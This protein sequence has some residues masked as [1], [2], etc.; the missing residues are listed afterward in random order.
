VVEEEGEGDESWR[1]CERKVL[2]VSMGRSFCNEFEAKLK[3][4]EGS[5][6]R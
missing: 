5:E 3:R 2:L 1:L 6:R 4:L